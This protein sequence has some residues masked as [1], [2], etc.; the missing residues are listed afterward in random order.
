MRLLE[1]MAEAEGE[2]FDADE[3]EPDDYQWVNLKEGTGEY[4]WAY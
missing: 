3:E 1:A 4:E 2:D